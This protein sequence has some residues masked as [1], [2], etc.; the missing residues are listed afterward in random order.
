MEWIGIA[1]AMF[2]VASSIAYLGFQ[3][4]SFKDILAERWAISD[5]LKEKMHK[6]QME[7]MYKVERIMGD[8]AD[9]LE[10]KV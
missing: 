8:I 3:V 5:E 6:E 7:V 2:V 1:L 9:T 4:L 10:E